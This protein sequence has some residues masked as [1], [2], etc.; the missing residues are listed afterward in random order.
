[1]KKK[2]G[3]STERLNEHIANSYT[4]T[5]TG[6]GGGAI[7]KYCQFYRGADP[8]LHFLETAQRIADELKTRMQKFRQRPPLS[9]VDE[10]LWV[11][12]EYC[13]LCERGGFT[14]YGKQ[15]ASLERMGRI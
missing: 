5:T 11:N 1:M 6:P 3:K 14:E 8:A 9:E 7:K 12:S 4:L 10:G 13:H 15:E 2:L